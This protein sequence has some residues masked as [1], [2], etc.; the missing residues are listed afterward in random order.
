MCVDTY[1]HTYIHTYIRICLHTRG[2]LVIMFMHLSVCM[3]VLVYL[4]I[5]WLVCV[6]FVICVFVSL[7]FM[8]QSSFV[9]RLNI[10]GEV[11][12]S[13]QALHSVCLFLMAHWHAAMSFLS[14]DTYLSILL[15]TRTSWR[16]MRPVVSFFVLIPGRM[17]LAIL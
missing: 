7:W 13:E 8:N 12:G 11:D 15:S 1:I 9:C 14:A 17:V 6:S 3:H 5:Y 4:C 16:H 10:H 2:V